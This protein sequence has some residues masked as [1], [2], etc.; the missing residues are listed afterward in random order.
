MKEEKNK[1]IMITI[2]ASILFFSGWWII[3]DLEAYYK[4]STMKHMNK[5]FH[6]CGFFGT[7]SLLIVNMIPNAALTSENTYQRF[8]CSKCFCRFW[9]FIGFC[10][11]FS[12]I[13][14]ATWI[15]IDYFAYAD[16]NGEEELPD[17]PPIALF[18]QNILIFVSSLLMR[19]G[20]SELP[21]F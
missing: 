15:L 1:N 5:S 17:W 16:A 21:Q 13:I 19:F 20:R 6:L 9:L 8:F 12:A 11:A 18:L 14:G 7:I 4:G 3:F 10:I 2:I